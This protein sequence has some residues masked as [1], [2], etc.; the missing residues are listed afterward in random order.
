MATLTDKHNPS[1]VIFP[2]NN[3]RTAWRDFGLPTLLV[4]PHVR[5]AGGVPIANSQVWNVRI[6]IEGA[7][8]EALVT[9]HDHVGLRFPDRELFARTLSTS[10]V[11]DR[12]INVSLQSFQK[13]DGTPVDFADVE[14]GDLMKYTTN[15]EVTD[16]VEYR[17]NADYYDISDIKVETEQLPPKRYNLIYSCNFFNRVVLTEEEAGID[18]LICIDLNLT[19]NGLLRFG[20]NHPGEVI[21][22]AHNL[23]PATYLTSDKKAQ[24][25]T[26]ELYR[27]FTDILQD[28][29]DEQRFLERMNW[30]SEVPFEAIP[31][32]SSLLG[33]DIPYYPTSLDQLRRVVLRKTRELQLLKGSQ[34]AIRQL[35]NLFGFT[36]LIANLWLALDDE[37]FVAPNEKLTD[38]LIGQEIT[39][40]EKFQV[41]PLLNAYNTDGFGDIDLMLLFRPQAISEIDE[42]SAAI[43]SGDL[44]INAYLVEV[45]SEAQAALETEFEAMET[46]PDTYGQSADCSVGSLGFIDC[47]RIDSALAGKETVGHSQLLLQDGIATD[48]NL[49]GI[50]PPLKITSQP[51][52]GG[53]RFEKEENNLKIV[54]ANHI[55]FGTELMLYAV[56]AYK[57]QDVQVPLPL[58]DRQSNRFNI[59]LIDRSSDDLIRNDVLEFMLDFIHKIKAFHS[60]LHV[61]KYRVD[62]NEAY[63]VTDICLGG[64]VSQRF[65]TD[66]GQWQVPPAVIPNTPT[67]SCDTLTPLA[68]GYKDIDLIY[69][70]L[71]LVGVLEE[72]NAW[73]ALD[74]RETI[75]SSFLKVMLNLPTREKCQYNEFGQ[76]RV[77][78][79]SQPEQLIGSDPSDTAN[80]ASHSNNSTQELHPDLPSK[81]SD[82]D[83]SVYSPKL[84]QK[85]T[86]KTAHCDT[87]G[88]TDY[89][90][91]G[92]VTDEL[93]IKYGPLL[94]EL[95]RCLPCGIGMGAGVYWVYPVPT[96]T[97]LTGV[98]KP[99]PNSRTRKVTFS[100]GF[101]SYGLIGYTEK[102]AQADYLTVDY[103]E[104]L[105]RNG[106]LSGL[107]RAYDQPQAESL[108]FDNRA[109][110]KDVAQSRNLAIHRPQLDINVPYMHFPG[111]RFITMNRLEND[112]SH[113]TWRAKPW[114]DPHSVDTPCCNGRPTWLNATLVTQPNGDTAL[115]YDDVPFTAQ[116]NNLVPDVSSLGSHDPISDTVV[117]SVYDLQLD[118]G[119]PA[120]SMESVCPCP[121]TDGLIEV[122]DPIF[123][124]ANDQG[125]GNYIDF[126][127][128]NPCETGTFTHTG[129]DLGR[130]GLYDELFDALEIPGSDFGGT[131]GTAQV[132]LLFKV[133]SGIRDGTTGLRLDC[134]CTLAG[135]PDTNDVLLSCM[136]SLFVNEDGNPDFNCDQLETIPALL[137]EEPL[138]VCSYRLDG[139]IPSLLEIK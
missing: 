72:F 139:S 130:E 37:T 133:G 43:D 25:T 61:V 17:Q 30:V 93:L 110:L 34:R 131:D 123:N 56:A 11:L 36:V 118:N 29:Y 12:R 115:S 101:R 7:P 70:R 45:G 84:I 94:E 77:R 10:E 119:H 15:T 108:H 88:V 81:S 57:R 127:E 26:L 46:A 13:T 109:Y 102:S 100:G 104:P 95:N 82:S 122:D 63:A 135:S 47:G 80:T 73:K 1:W 75:S 85:D 58:V 5:T 125:T 137:C 98:Q 96:T 38:E 22:E 52:L 128:G 138:G 6:S 79:T 27:P 86:A 83:S 124:S 99:C 112:F 76:D 97:V 59:Q 16:T 20:L 23:T 111:T 92:R 4:I 64:D 21:R 114:D 90:Y 19:G 134:G 69:R 55:D 14:T 32:L 136:S 71:L 116:G 53:V 44:T 66:L 121:T 60:L 67:E 8:N 24:D 18:E 105:P 51:H 9:G 129:T 41:E 62:F 2:H 113:S 49:A 42:F 74:D 87:D 89:C 35:M 117:H 40:V 50:S 3:D 106:Y 120:I 48:Q 31:Y 39:F 126:C 54:F 103:N 33:W 91:K 132:D 65:D 28:V 78:G 68:L 107:L